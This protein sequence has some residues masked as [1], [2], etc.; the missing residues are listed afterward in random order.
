MLGTGK[1]KVKGRAMG[2]K[3]NGHW[4]EAQVTESY[5]IRKGS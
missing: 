3:T 2:H 4:Y 5:E 1:M